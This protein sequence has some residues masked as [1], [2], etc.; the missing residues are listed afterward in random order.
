VIF[1]GC[2]GL[3][4]KKRCHADDITSLIAALSSD[5]TALA[6]S[7]MGELKSLIDELL[8][9]F[10]LEEL[11]GIFS[12]AAVELIKNWSELDKDPYKKCQLMFT[13]MK[14]ITLLILS[15]FTG[16]STLVNAGKSLDKIKQILS[17]LFNILR[18][19]RF[20]AM[21]L[22]RLCKFFKNERIRAILIQLGIGCFGSGT[23]VLTFVLVANADTGALEWKEQSVPIESIRAGDRVAT[24]EAIDQIS[25]TSRV[26]SRQWRRVGLMLYGADHSGNE[27][28]VQCEVLVPDSWLK[29]NV[30]QADRFCVQ[31]SSS[32]P[33]D[34]D[35]LGIRGQ[36]WA[37]LLYNEVCPDIQLGPGQLVMATWHHVTQEPMLALTIR[38]PPRFDAISGSTETIYCTPEHRLFSARRQ[39]WVSASELEIDE[40]LASNLRQPGSLVRVIAIQHL[41]LASTVVH[42]LTVEHAHQFL[43]AK[44]NVLAHNMSKSKKNADCDAPSSVGR[45][46]K[47]ARLREL[48][49]DPNVSSA[50]RGWIR[51]EINQIERG[52]RKTIR[53]PGSSRKRVLDGEKY[54]GN[55]GKEL[56][57]RRGFEAR[58]GYGYEHS[59]LQ[60]KVLHKLQHKHEGYK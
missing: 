29:T 44:A 47:Q 3:K 46:G 60:D 32:F 13:M 17:R 52:K 50:D 51:Q 23:M 10:E 55:S 38:G 7:L 8:G 42:N 14:D 56:A 16:G 53:L 1:A 6:Q 12:P 54:G 26:N 57:H 25:Q 59:D 34:G 19:S 35:E 4:N 28:T 49:D 2:A 5:P 41:P 9:E 37:T 21:R 36:V 40:P 24:G 33:L 31:P 58:K 15:F 30:A 27:K 20:A 22:P 45:S 11:A 18:S 43:V 48:A 39:A